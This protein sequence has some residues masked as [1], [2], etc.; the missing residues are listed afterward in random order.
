MP[1]DPA[2]TEQL[3]KELAEKTQAYLD[4]RDKVAP[5]EEKLTRENLNKVL[6]L[7][8]KHLAPPEA[9]PLSEV[10]TRNV[11]HFYV[12]EKPCKECLFSEERIVDPQ[13]KKQ[14]LQ[15][16]KGQGGHFI[17]HKATMDQGKD[18]ACASWAEK[19]G[20]TSNLYRV[21]QRLGRVQLVKLPED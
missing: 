3:L 20:D 10:R 21:S 4:A 14:V 2:A 13:R 12:F 7:A 1:T 11:E 5:V 15:K 6:S 9:I 18:V 16:L 8:R 19:M 17:C